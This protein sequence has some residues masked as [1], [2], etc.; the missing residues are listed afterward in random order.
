MIS[1]LKK[2]L[3][4]TTPLGMYARARRKK[5]LEKK[6]HKWECN[7]LTPSM[8]HLGKQNI[9]LEYTKR[10]PSKVFIETGTYKGDMVYAVLPHFEKIYSIELDKTLSEKAQKRFAGYRSVSVVQ[11]SSKDVLPEI[12]RDVKQSC[13]FWLDAHYSGG[14]TAKG[15]TE[16]PIMQEL[17]CILSHS[18]AAD[19]VIL[20]DDAR[21]FVGGNDYPLI[22]E[23]ECYILSKFPNWVFYIKDDIIQAHKKDA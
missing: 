2:F 3:E 8:P 5:R 17:E 9:V 12:L 19:H 22:K 6:L 1:D 13:L 11:G 16:T 18:Y 21:C 14:R 10:F 23:V 4:R 20:I 7:K 15:D